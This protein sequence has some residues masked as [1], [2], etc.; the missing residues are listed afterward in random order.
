MKI[1]CQRRIGHVSA[2]FVRET[3]D[4]HARLAIS[5]HGGGTLIRH[6]VSLTQQGQTGLL[7]YYRDTH[8]AVQ[9]CRCPLPR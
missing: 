3:R 6:E 4:A 9:V 7:I 8:G 5:L 2:R 1:L